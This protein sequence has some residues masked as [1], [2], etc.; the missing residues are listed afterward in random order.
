MKDL[1]GEYVLADVVPGTCVDGRRRSH[2]QAEYDWLCNDRR[3]ECIVST[4]IKVGG[5][6]DLTQ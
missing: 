3:V 2:S 1:G 4:L 6:L 5:F